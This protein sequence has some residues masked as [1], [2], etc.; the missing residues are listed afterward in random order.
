MSLVIVN[1]DE[2]NCPTYA[3]PK[4]T[5]VHTGAASTK[6]NVPAAKNTTVWRYADTAIDDSE[7]IAMKPSYKDICAKGGNQRKERV[8]FRIGRSAAKG[9]CDYKIVNSA[10]KPDPRIILY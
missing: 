1:T 10:C 2:N 6:G 4:P 8:V 3:R 5:T 7:E 9:N